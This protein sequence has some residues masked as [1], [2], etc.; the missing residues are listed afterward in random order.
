MA[1][2]Q[3]DDVLRLGSWKKLVL[4]IAELVFERTRA[5]AR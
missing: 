1:S 3:T 2:S 5:I 4:P